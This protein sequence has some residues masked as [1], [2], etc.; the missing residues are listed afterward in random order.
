[1]VP[2]ALSPFL[3]FSLSLF[4][5]LSLFLPLSLSLSLSL[6]LS[7]SL[8]P[9]PPSLA[10]ISACL[11]C[12]CPVYSYCS[13]G[14]QLFTEFGDRLPGQSRQ[15]RGLLHVRIPVSHRGGITGPASDIIDSGDVGASSTSSTS[16]ASNTG[17]ATSPTSGGGDIST[18]SAR[19]TECASGGGDTA[20]GQ[21]SRVVVV[22]NIHAE[23]PVPGNL[24]EETRRLQVRE[25]AGHLQHVS[26]PRLVS[27][28]TLASPHPRLTC[29]LQ[30]NYR[31]RARNQN[32]KCVV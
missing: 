11:S 30:P 25:Q 29:S 3:S 4:L 8:C 18:S 32:N 31:E 1:M 23:S 10:L 17:P 27:L 2:R 15:G 7:L 28:V 16:S 26:T 20:L 9:P 14:N 5:A 24:N 12:T 13:F 21:A 22:G 6:F 19:G